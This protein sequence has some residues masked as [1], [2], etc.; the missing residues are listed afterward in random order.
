MKNY[1][2][3]RGV[4]QGQVM[5]RSVSSN[6]LIQNTDGYAILKTGDF[7][8]NGWVQVPILAV[9]KSNGSSQHENHLI[10]SNN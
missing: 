10:D 6:A 3:D 5:V 9:N 1:S 4:N 7:K 8:D 2:E